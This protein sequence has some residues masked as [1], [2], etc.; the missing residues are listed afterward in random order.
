[1]GLHEMLVVDEALRAMIRRRAPASELQAA[2]LA[3]GMA[4]LRQDGIEKVLT[5]DTDMA[6]VLAAT[7][8]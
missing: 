1:M 8:T 5:G 7:N 6:E 2:G 4:T 3:T